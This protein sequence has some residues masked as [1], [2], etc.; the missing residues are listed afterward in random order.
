MYS[1]DIQYLDLKKSCIHATYHKS[2]HYLT[3]MTDNGAYY[4]IILGM[5]AEKSVCSVFGMLLAQDSDE[6]MT[7]YTTTHQLATM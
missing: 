3:L 6:Y 5:S 2:R 7:T 4:F 1:H